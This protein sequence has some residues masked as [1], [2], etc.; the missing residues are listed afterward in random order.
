MTEA[1]R[2][3]RTRISSF[4]NTFDLVPI[5][6]ALAADDPGYATALLADDEQLVR[7]SMHHEE[8]RAFRDAH[9]AIFSAFHA[10]LGHDNA[11]V[12][13]TALV[14]AIPLTERPLLTQ[15]HASL[16]S[17]AR[18]LLATSTDRH[19]RDRALDALKA[20]GHDTSG[21]ENASDI[22]AREQYALLRAARA[23]W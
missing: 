13:H 21:L 12:R 19:P 16:A 15:H 2:S 9:P 5:A 3:A 23:S 18:R 8:M 6:R 17:H 20:W 22:A 14:A 10:F 7:E 11:D 4:A 1:E